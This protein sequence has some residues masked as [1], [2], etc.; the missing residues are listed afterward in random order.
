MRP[1]VDEVSQVR[2]TGPRPETRPSLSHPLSSP[3]SPSLPA[4]SVSHRVTPGDAALGR[5]TLGSSERPPRVT[6]PSAPHSRPCALLKR[7]VTPHSSLDLKTTR[8]FLLFPKPRLHQG[9]RAPL[10]V[11]CPRRPPSD[12]TGLAPPPPSI[13]TVLLLRD[14]SA[15]RS[16]EL[17]LR[18]P[19][20]PL[21]PP[22]RSG[23]VPEPLSLSPVLGQPCPHL[24]SEH[25]LIPPGST[26]LGLWSPRVHIAGTCV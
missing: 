13:N 5:A 12:H 20:L 7:E 17:D 4:A 10:Q 11:L 9:P 14:V 8:A 6:S 19:A 1:G 25:L 2:D 18:G 15:F 16:L 23:P 22:R 3:P 21:P 26:L 24:F